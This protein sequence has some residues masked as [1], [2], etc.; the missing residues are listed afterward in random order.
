MI[1]S[2][3]I[4]AATSYADPGDLCVIL[5]VF[6]M[7]PGSEKQANFELC[8][9]LY[10]LSGIPLVV[11]ECAFGESA[12]ACEPGPGVYRVRA[13]TALWQKERLIN[14]ALTRV[15]ARCTKVAWIDADILFENTQWA[16]TASE[17]L[18]DLVVVQL[19]DRIIR[20][21]RG[22]REYCGTGASWEGFAAV[23]ARDPNALLLGDFG[24]HGHTGFAWAAR[25]SVLEYAGL[26]DAC[27]CGGADHVMAHAFCGDWESPCLTRMLGAGSA[28]YSHAAAWA[29]RIYPLVK[30]RVGFVEGAALHLWHGE[31]ATRKHLRRY[32][33][34]W[35]SQF[36]PQCDLGVDESGCWSWRSSKSLLQAEVGH[37]L[38]GRRREAASQDATSCIPLSRS[39]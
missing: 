3:P 16:V 10:A 9:R 19:A 26:Y 25:R 5:C 4:R 13:T 36:D 32:R 11:I 20:L 14:L 27:V 15:P 29:S 39:A 33:A 7:E 1:A 12:W 8:R 24:M 22:A 21:P 38:A 28:W 35:D 31:I 30:A 18:N 6:N 23:Y 34:L 2:H 37:Y 17:R